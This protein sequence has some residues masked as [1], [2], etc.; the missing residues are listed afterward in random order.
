M[1]SVPCTGVGVCVLGGVGSLGSARRPGFVVVVVVVVLSLSLSLS[2]WWV[3]C[4]GARGLVAKWG[5]PQG[6]KNRGVDLREI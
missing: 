3:P 2:L 4:V 6:S 5:F 1:T